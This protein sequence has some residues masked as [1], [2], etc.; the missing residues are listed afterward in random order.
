MRPAPEEDVFPCRLSSPVMTLMREP[1]WLRA[2]S[3]TFLG[4]SCSKRC[5]G[6]LPAEHSDVDNASRNTTYINISI[7]E[8]FI[9]G[10]FIPV[11]FPGRTL[12]IHCYICCT[13]VRQL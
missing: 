5:T 8:Y 6:L 2:S 7:D 10:H 11:L 9:G 1:S 12:S 13:R 3:E 4:T